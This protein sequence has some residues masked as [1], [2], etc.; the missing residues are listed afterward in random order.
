MI[1][2]PQL[3]PG[4]QLTTLYDR[5]FAVLP[6]STPELLDAAHL[7]RYQVYCVENAFENPAQHPGQRET[8]RYDAHSVHAV[9]IY[10]P[11][12]QVVGCVRLIL[13]QPEGGLS[14]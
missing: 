6:A 12:R 8:D 7:L 13:P 10:I 11:T 2:D 4:A 1:R 5:Y 14:T 9:L 3:T